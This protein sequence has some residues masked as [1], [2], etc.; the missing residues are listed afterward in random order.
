MLIV[1]NVWNWRNGVLLGARPGIEKDLGNLGFVASM[2]NV[3]SSG[4]QTE[5]TNNQAKAIWLTA[6]SRFEAALEIR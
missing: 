6:C 4:M 1:L 3:T 2:N 5:G